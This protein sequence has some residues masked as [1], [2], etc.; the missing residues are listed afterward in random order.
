MSEANRLRSVRDAP[1][2]T[3]GAPAVLTGLLPMG[4]GSSPMIVA[5]GG[6]CGSRYY[7]PVKRGLERPGQQEK[8]SHA[9]YSHTAA[10]RRSGCHRRR[11]VPSASALAFEH[12]NVCPF[13]GYPHQVCPQGSTGKP[14]SM[15]TQGRNGTGCVPYTVNFKAV[16]AMPTGLSLSSSGL[17]SG[18]PT[19][20]GD[21][22]FWVDMQDIPASSGGI[23]WCSR[24]QVD[25]GA[26][27]NLDRGACR[28]CSVSRHS[29]WRR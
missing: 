11:C 13:A 1:S 9:S 23:S 10:T 7:P 19:Q 24:Q 18:T 15:Q 22:T 26:V 2:R 3:N 25:R 4:A 8:G 27:P 20:T 5:A 17:I 6:I 29:V 21:W 12:D 14:Y 16:G 28:S